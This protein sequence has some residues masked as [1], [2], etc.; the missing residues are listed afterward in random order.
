[1]VSKIGTAPAACHHVEVY[2]KAC[3]K[4]ALRLWVSGAG[5]GAGGASRRGAP[6]PA[7]RDL[8]RPLPNT[9]PRGRSGLHIIYRH[10]SGITSSSTL[11]PPCL[12]SKSKKESTPSISTGH[13]E[14]SGD[15]RHIPNALGAVG[16]QSGQWR[17]AT[18]NLGTHKLQG[19]G[20]CDLSQ[21]N[22]DWV[23]HTEDPIFSDLPRRDRYLLY[24]VFVRDFKW[25]QVADALQTSIIDAKRR[26]AS[27]LEAIRNFATL[28]ADLD[29]PVI[30][31]AA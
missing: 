2:P 29:Y 15:D 25:E 16:N 11:N 28:T 10:G 13:V 5:A 30:Q 3:D 22:L 18:E 27:V 4:S 26:L 14:S 1:M 7:D 17:A 9:S 8:G 20:G 19:L 21:M 24:L 6:L 12:N 31:K 23:A